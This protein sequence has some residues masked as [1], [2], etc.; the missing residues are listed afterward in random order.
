[1]AAPSDLDSA[2]PPMDITAFILELPAW[3]DTRK[4]PKGRR[5]SCSPSR[6]Q[7]RTNLVGAS[8]SHKGQHSR[9]K[10]SKVAFIL[11]LIGF[12]VQSGDL[13]SASSLTSKLAGSTSA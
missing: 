11:S 5:F 9:R 10:C 3:S 7:A 12:F 2:S 1:M 4:P 13:L 8:D 6:L